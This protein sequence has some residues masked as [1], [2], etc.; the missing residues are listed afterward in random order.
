MRQQVDGQTRQQLVLAAG[1]IGLGR[2]EH[3]ATPD[4]RP[5]EPQEN[6][7]QFCLRWEHR[8]A[9]ARRIKTR[10]L[11]EHQDET[12]D[13]A[14]VG[15]GHAP[16]AECVRDG[17]VAREN[18]VEGLDVAQ[19][20]P[21]VRCEQQVVAQVAHAAAERRQGIP[22]NIPAGLAKHRR[23]ARRAQGGR[24]FCVPGELCVPARIA[25]GLRDATVV[26]GPVS[27]VAA[28]AFLSQQDARGR[29]GCVMHRGH[30]PVAA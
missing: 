19:V 29:V 2:Q 26:G 11:H 28:H 13:L 23:H 27:A 6:P 8:L 16:P 21:H 24:G 12:T 15:A 3:P 4:Q 7:Q 1:D 10:V 17:D 25:E 5:E 20:T 30:P 18:E 14:G 9:G 22:R